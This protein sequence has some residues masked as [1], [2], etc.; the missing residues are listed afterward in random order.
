[1][2]AGFRR[3][4]PGYSKWNQQDVFWNVGVTPNAGLIVSWVRWLDGIAHEDLLTIFPPYPSQ[5]GV[6]RNTF[7]PVPVVVD[8]P[9]GSAVHSAIWSLDTPKTAI[10]EV[11]IARPGRKPAWRQAP[12]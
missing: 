10:P 2:G 6:A 5:D 8:P 7:I 3:L 11:F 1:V 12:R 4:G 9:P